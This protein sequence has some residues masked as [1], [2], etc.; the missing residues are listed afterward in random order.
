MKRGSARLVS[1]DSPRLLRARALFA[2]RRYDQALALFDEAVRAEPNNIK[3]LADAARA[4]GFRY[5]YRQAL[6]LLDRLLQIA[7]GRA[8]AHF[9]AGETYRMLM[10]GERAIVCFEKAISLA[11]RL[12]AAELELAILYERGH[13][14]DEATVHI[15]R[16]L[17]GSPVPVT[18]HLVHARIQRR[19]GDVAAAEATLRRLAESDATPRVVA[20]E[21]WADL[22]IL[23]DELGN[24]DEAWNAILRSKQILLARD[25]AERTA[26]E[27]VFGR[28]ARTVDAI[29]A[30]HFAR[31]ASRPPASEPLRMAV[32]TGFPRSGTTLLEAVLDAHPDVT[33]SEERDVLAGEV[34]PALGAGHAVDSPVEQVLE[35]LSPEQIAHERS[36]YV[37]YMEAIL[38]EPIGTRLHID[39]NPAINLMIPVV[40][41]LFPES[42]LI[43]AL[44]DPRDVLLS[45]FLRY[46]PLNPVSVWFLTIERLAERYSLDMRAWLKFRQIVK[47]PYIE[48]RYEDTISDLESVARRTLSAL[49]VPW[50]DTVLGYRARAQDKR[51]LSPTYEAVAKPLY[52]HA[53]GRWT[54]YERHFAPVLPRL[55]PFVRA[56]GYEA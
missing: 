3:A 6:K 15:E 53:I 49:D 48:V 52:G 2:E 44:R 16:V 9:Y 38:P 10:L 37:R 17:A 40:Q 19:R 55:A 8:D 46:L 36:R 39:K 50:N 26:A 33:S 43:I 24:Y 47:M 11:G 13:R 21:A 4:H 12:P 34:F 27:H 1:I 23:L 54:R 41:R 29:T 25:A 20:S 35:G 32:L 18:A 28:F 5:D 31:W 30:D 51:V 14:L 22:A 45:C 42:R 7:Q 56:F